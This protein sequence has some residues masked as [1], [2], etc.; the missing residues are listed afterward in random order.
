MN[1]VEIEQAVSDLFAE[2]LDPAESATMAKA[3][4]L[5]YASDAVNL[6]GRGAMLDV[7][8]YAIYA[9]GILLHSAKR[10]LAT[11]AQEAE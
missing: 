6:G 9:D 5:L 3:A 10:L 2:P 4:K 11:G 1:A 7:L 8:D